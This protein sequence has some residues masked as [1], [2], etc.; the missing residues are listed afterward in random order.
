MNFSQYDQNALDLAKNFKYPEKSIWKS[1]R[2][3]VNT[4]FDLAGNLIDSIPGIGEA[5]NKSTNGLVTLFNEAAAY[6]VRKNAILEEFRNDGNQFINSL[7][8]IFKLNLENVDKTV[9]HLA[10]KYN[11]LA[12]AEGATVAGA[13]YLAG[14][15]MPAAALAAIVADVPVFTG[16]CLRAIGEYATYYGFDIDRQEERAYALYILGLT[17]TS[18]S[19]RNALIANLTKLSTQMAKKVAWREL[20]NS[21][22]VN[23]VKQIAQS[24]G[25]RVTKGKLAMVVPLAG[26]GINTGFNTYMMNKV[27]DASYILYRERFLSIK[28]SN[29]NLIS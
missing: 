2:E 9:G 25:I 17:S 15:A 6:T 14:P 4:P 19:A 18:T 20:D 12:A 22:F 3:V 29:K 8:D 13:P 24:F 23:I 16:L 7:D 21:I 26:I 27:C 10:T 28:Y 5:L 11:A 1:I